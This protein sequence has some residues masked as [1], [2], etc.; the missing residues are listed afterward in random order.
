MST[1]P[2]LV[3][4]YNDPIAKAPGR[5]LYFIGTGPEPHKVVVEQQ[6]LDGLG[7]E[8]WATPAGTF[9][10]AWAVLAYVTR[11]LAMGKIT[12]TQ[13]GDIT[14]VDARETIIPGPVPAAA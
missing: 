5:I 1:K 6:G 8:R 10:N 2:D 9:L 7:N 12:A 13:D 3:I 11:H 4:L 14:R